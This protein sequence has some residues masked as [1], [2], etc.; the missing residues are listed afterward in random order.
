M[1]LILSLKFHASPLD[2]KAKRKKYR[3][4]PT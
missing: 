3:V 2:E 4:S 1:I